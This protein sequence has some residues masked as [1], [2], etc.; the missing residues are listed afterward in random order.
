MESERRIIITGANGSGKTTL[1]KHLFIEL[2]STKCVIF[3]DIDNIK[4][5]DSKKIIKHVFEDTYGTDPSDYIRF[6]QLPPEEKV[7]IIDDIDQIRPQTL[8][9]YISSVSNEFGY[10]IFATKKVLNL[11]MV[12]RMRSALNTSKNICKYKVSPFYA[13]KRREL[14]ERVIACKSN[15]EENV[16]Q[17][18]DSLCDAIRMQKRFITFSPE[19]IVSFTEFYHNNLGLAFTSDSSVFSKVFEAN[20]TAALSP[21]QTPNISVDKMFTLI[22]LVAHYIHITKYDILKMGSRS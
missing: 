15:G 10:M 17:T 1:L 19:F 11:D 7:L 6:L 16:E 14:I 22:S 12:E 20:I 8:D 4:N 9:A 21:Y 18:V 13:D 2:S 3:C 5:K